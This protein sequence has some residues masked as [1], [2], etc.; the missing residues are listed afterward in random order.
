MSEDKKAVLKVARAKEKMVYCGPTIRGVANQYP[1]FEGGV[2][3]KLEEWADKSTAIKALIV[4]LEK[5]ALT[6]ERVERQ[7]TA[8]NVLFQKA[9]AVLQ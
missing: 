6:R 4:P 5:F 8:E 3:D 1:V 2:P 7:G 9:Q